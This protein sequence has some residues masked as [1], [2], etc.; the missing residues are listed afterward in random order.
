MASPTDAQ[1]PRKQHSE[2][3]WEAASHCAH[4]ETS[5]T[6]SAAAGRHGPPPGAAALTKRLVR[7]TQ[8]EFQKLCAAEHD[9][10]QQS[11][12]GRRGCAQF[13]W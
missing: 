6:S 8:S 10:R 12:A 5:A 2:M 7:V 11:I 1:T 13:S 9:H 4:S 3:S